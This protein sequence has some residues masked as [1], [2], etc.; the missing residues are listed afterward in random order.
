MQILHTS[1][2]RSWRGG[3]QQ[4]AYLLEELRELG[5]SQ[6]LVCAA[7]GELANWALARAFTVH[8]VSRQPWAYALALR[9][10]LQ[11]IAHL[12]QH[13]LS[14]VNADIALAIELAHQLAKGFV[15]LV[16]HKLNESCD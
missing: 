4:L 9:R 3:E 14:I 6:Q 12:A 5:V 2:P 7:G 10:L 8:Q 15:D 13:L 1:I 11:R 16:E